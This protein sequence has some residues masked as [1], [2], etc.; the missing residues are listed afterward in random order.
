[1]PVSMVDHSHDEKKFPWYQI[2]ILLIETCVQRKQLESL[3][4]ASLLLEITSVVRSISTAPV[5]FVLWRGV[6]QGSCRTT[7]A[8]LP[9][10]PRGFS[11][12]SA[13]R[14][15]LLCGLCGEV[16]ACQ[17]FA[18]FSWFNYSLI[19]T[20]P[21]FFYEEQT[22]D[23]DRMAFQKLLCTS[24]EHFP[25]TFPHLSLD[26]RGLSSLDWLQSP[27]F[28]N[29]SV[30]NT[31]IKLNAFHVG[32]QVTIVD[33]LVRLNY[34]QQLQQLPLVLALTP[35]SPVRYNTPFDEFHTLFFSYSLLK[36]GLKHWH[37][38]GH[39]NIFPATSSQK[40]LETQNCV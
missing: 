2:R 1:M 15:K 22:I 3:S 35:C 39:R 23:T 25:A 19:I 14:S 11:A 17:H 31:D 9:L 10:L 8:S 12:L 27:N 24:R 32:A 26:L 37:N 5:G 6:R 4:L 16:A 30:A 33:I 13:D 40:A 34:R 20:L 18:L 28:N 29:D 38:S 36:D 7:P 21:L